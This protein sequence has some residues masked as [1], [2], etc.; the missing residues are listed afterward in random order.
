MGCVQLPACLPRLPL[1]AHTVTMPMGLVV[2]LAG[3][4]A[5]HVLAGWLWG[6]VVQV[7]SAAFWTVRER[8]RKT[9]YRQAWSKARAVA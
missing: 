1:A 3:W 8:G 2:C 4:L 6:G 9:G 5:D 7:P